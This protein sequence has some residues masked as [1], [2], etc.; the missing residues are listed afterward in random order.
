MENRESWHREA[1]SSCLLSD[2]AE[3][4]GGILKLSRGREEMLS[5]PI[6][7]LTDRWHE[8]SWCQSHGE[9]N[10]VENWISVEML[11]GWRQSVYSWLLFPVVCIKNQPKTQKL[12]CFSIITLPQRVRCQNSNHRLSSMYNSSSFIQ[13]ILSLFWLLNTV[14]AFSLLDEKPTVVRDGYLLCPAP[15]LHEVGQ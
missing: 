13:H 12:I 15:H 6:S 7:L 1:N 14:C 10:H 8:L 11:L 5:L 9:D 3:N 4:R 2:A